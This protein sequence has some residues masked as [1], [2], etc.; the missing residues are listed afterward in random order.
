M[1]KTVNDERTRINQGT[2]D[3]TGI[4]SGWADLPVV[5]QTFHWCPDY[6]LAAAESDRILKPKG[7]LALIWNLE[8]RQ[9]ITT[10]RMRKYFAF[11][12]VEQSG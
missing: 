1:S 6:E 10:L 2:Y 12:G 11:V 9:A 7:T 4:E 5:A 3:A 8:D